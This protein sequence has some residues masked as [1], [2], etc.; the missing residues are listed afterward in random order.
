MNALREAKNLGIPT[1]CLID[2]DGDPEFS[3]I[4]IP[5]NDDS[6]RAIDIVIRELCAAVEEGRSARVEAAATQGERAEGAASTTE[7]DA[8]EGEAAPRS[9]RGGRSLFRGRARG[10][11]AR[12]PESSTPA[13]AT[14]AGA[15]KV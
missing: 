4:P 15:D 14:P 8:P 10:D 7:G 9:S 3:D 13:D 2:S 6:M 1:I 5:G 12:A 11:D